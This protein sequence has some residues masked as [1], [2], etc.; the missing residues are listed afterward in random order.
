MTIERERDGLWRVVCDSCGDDRFLEGD[1][2]ETLVGGSGWV[3][4]PPETVKFV[5]SGGLR[6]TYREHACSDCA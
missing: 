4:R 3:A 2:V 5:Q 1:D 6:V